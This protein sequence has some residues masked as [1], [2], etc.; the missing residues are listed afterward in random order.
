MTDNRRQWGQAFEFRN[1]SGRRA[2]DISLL[3]PSPARRDSEACDANDSG[4]NDISGI[5][6]YSSTASSLW[7]CSCCGMTI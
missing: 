3:N 5:T 6:S 4:T 7:P 2:N 1:G